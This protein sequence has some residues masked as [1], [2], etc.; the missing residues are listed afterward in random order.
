MLATLRRSLPLSTAK[1]ASSSGETCSGH[2]P[3]MLDNGDSIVMTNALVD[4]SALIGYHAA[5][6]HAGGIADDRI[7]PAVEHQALHSARATES[8][9]AATPACAPARRPIRQAYADNRARRLRQDH[10]AR[11]LAPPE[12]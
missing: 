11:R 8:G 2:A 3:G 4:E 5:I 10:A 12:R 9:V 7:H 1:P 6:L